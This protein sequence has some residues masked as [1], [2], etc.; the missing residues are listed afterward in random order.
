MPLKKPI[1]RKR[2][3]S[4]ASSV[5]SLFSQRG[6]PNTKLPQIISASNSGVNTRAIASS[7]SKNVPAFLNKLYK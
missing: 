2:S 7:A 1:S 4:N 3:L 6:V 5:A